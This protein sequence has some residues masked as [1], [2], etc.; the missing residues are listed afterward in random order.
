M[1]STQAN[2]WKSHRNAHIIGFNAAGKRYAMTI[3]CYSQRLLNPFRGSVCCIQY[4]SAE[5][6]T[7]DGVRWDIYVSND[8]LLADLP[9]DHHTQVSD[10]R[11]GS[12]SAQTGLKRGPL[13]PSEEFLAMEEMGAAV[14]E[15]LLR[16]HD[17]LPFPFMDRHELWLLDRQARPLALIDSAL[18][19]DGIDLQKTSAW[20]PGLNCRKTFSSKA[21]TA[22]GVNPETTGA[23]ADYLAGYINDCAGE[24]P[25]MQIFT[26]SDD[27]KGTG[28]HGINLD[29]THYSRLL[30][31]EE[32]PETLLDTR[33]HDEA[34]R[35]LISDFTAWQAP[36]LLLLPAL[37][38]ETRR[39]HEQYA[40]SQPL[41]LVQ[42]YH[43]YPEI[44]DTASI[45]AARVEVRLRETVPDPEQR[46]QTMS[47]F[48][49][50]LGP[51][52]A[53]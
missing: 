8:G 20:T 34:H 16:V 51:E 39:R 45:E 4:Q 22:L 50:E 26:R 7:A 27:G 25:A 15:H 17:T 52:G 18:D 32:F 48:Y 14:Y 21:A 10:I 36:W 41:K 35:Q 30:P 38:G 6:V 2:P 33:H 37:Q 23:A 40:R 11:Y 5:A 9:D 46:E 47:T 43:L 31:L 19:A 28:L 29:S 3:L 24:I 1:H 12:W 13:Y 44:V 53:D 49:V 42:H